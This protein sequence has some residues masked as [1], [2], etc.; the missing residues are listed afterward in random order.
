MTSIYLF[1]IKKK[2]VFTV[3]LKKWN[4]L[5]SQVFPSKQ[6]REVHLWSYQ[7]IPF[8]FLC[9]CLHPVDM[10]L[11][12]CIIISL[13][14]WWGLFHYPPLQSFGWLRFFKAPISIL[15]FVRHHHC[16]RN[17]I[18]AFILHLSVYILYQLSC[19]WRRMI[20][21]NF[22]FYKINHLQ[23]AQVDKNYVKGHDRR[24]LQ[25]NTNYSYDLI[26]VYSWLYWNW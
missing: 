13:N 25:F 6:I 17:I 19:F 20:T 16:I 4:W 18:S 5:F 1:L 23:K 12:G 7:G 21:P 9:F 15:A 14:M 3:N 24:R 22:P 2:R 8:C 11:L 10:F 26:T